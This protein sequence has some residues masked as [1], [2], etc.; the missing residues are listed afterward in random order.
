MLWILISLYLVTVRLLAVL[1]TVMFALA[2]ALPVLEKK[3]G[4][5]GHV[6]RLALVGV[7]D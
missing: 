7:D 4:D 2:A 3:V 1:T 6:Y 5:L